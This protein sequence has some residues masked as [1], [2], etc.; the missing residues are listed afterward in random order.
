MTNN[1]LHPWSAYIYAPAHVPNVPHIA[2]IVFRKEHVLTPG[3]DHGDP[4]DH[5]DYTGAT[6][7]AFS[8]RDGASGL[9]AAASAIKDI[10]VVC[11]DVAA[12]LTA[13]VKTV[14]TLS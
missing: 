2:V 14:A 10:T 5:V 11:L 6:Y 3:Y 8:S 13:T 7:Y 12:G 1:N 9:V 4:P